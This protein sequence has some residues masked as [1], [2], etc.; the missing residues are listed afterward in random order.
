M[1]K[2]AS[3]ITISVFLAFIGLFFAL[4]LILPDR[5]FSEQENRF[6]TKRPE[7][8]LSA[9]TSGKFTADFEKYTTDQFAGRDSWTAL[10]A[11]CE[12]LLGKRENN[13][14]YLCENET[15][16]EAFTA[17][18]PK[19]LSDNMSHIEKLRENTE[20]EVF[21]A[22]I[23]GKSELWGGMLPIGA[24][25]DSETAVINSCYDLTSARC[26]DLLSPLAE[27]SG[28][29]IYYRTDHHWT[30]RGAFYAAEALTEAM[31][32]AAPEAG[33]IRVLS[34]EF[35]GTTYSS[36]GFSWIAPDTMESWIDAPEGLSVTNHPEGKP[37]EGALYDESRLELKD[38][39]SYFMGGN[40]PL[41]SIV[42]ENY[43]APS[44]LII[45]D[46]YADSLVPFLLADFFRIDLIDPRYYHSSMSAYINENDFDMVLV[47]YSVRNFS[48]DGNVFFI[49]T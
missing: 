27:K 12:L 49:G 6:L 36:S 23:P 43:D 18:E 32:L 25:N 8:S 45:R 10:K 34:E 47:M 1:S 37:V 2:K 48:E 7:F 41:Q 19:K 39:Y 42:T 20:A 14:V 35:Y 15:L 17:P 4:N 22:L 28:E 21:F 16:I 30:S 3:Y 44:L 26:V 5:E 11:R 9:L 31:G 24:P 13:G 29:Y 46:S 38:K 40:S 33:D